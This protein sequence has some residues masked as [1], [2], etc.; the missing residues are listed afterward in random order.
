MNNTNTTMLAIACFAVAGVMAGVIWEVIN[1]L[2]MIRENREFTE[3]CKD[4]M[5]ECEI[6]QVNISEPWKSLCAY[7]VPKCERLTAVDFTI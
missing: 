4:L 5:T 1:A 3:I 2:P 6:H 7:E